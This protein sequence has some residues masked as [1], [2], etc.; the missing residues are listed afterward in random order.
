MA[1]GG[2]LFLSLS[3]LAVAVVASAVLAVAVTM[4]VAATMDADANLF[5]YDIFKKAK[6]I[7]A[8][9]F[10]A[11]KTHRI[12]DYIYLYGKKSGANVIFVPDFLYCIQFLVYDS[13]F[14]AV[15]F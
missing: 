2:L 13:Y 4:A 15:F 6:P 10:F 8:L 1:A 12:F 7:A 3:F 14:V 9:L 11:M 5:F